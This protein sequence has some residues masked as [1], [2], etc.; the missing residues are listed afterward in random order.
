MAL[1]F[2]ALDNCYPTFLFSLKILIKRHGIC[3]PYADH[4]TGALPN[5]NIGIL[6]YWFNW[7]F[8]NL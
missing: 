6:E 2:T 7:I 5:W 4:M 3:K 1:I 8:D